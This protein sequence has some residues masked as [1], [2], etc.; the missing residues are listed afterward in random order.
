MPGWIVALGAG[1]HVVAAALPASN[2]VSDLARELH[3]LAAPTSFQVTLQNGAE[4]FRG[5]LL[6]V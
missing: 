3:Y 4:P 6:P 2:G 1:A 5:P